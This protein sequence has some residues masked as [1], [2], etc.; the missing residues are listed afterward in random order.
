MLNENPKTIPSKQKTKIKK[1]KKKS[2]KTKSEACI[3]E[4]VEQVFDKFF[5]VPE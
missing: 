3:R 5:L 1:F 4:I 2:K